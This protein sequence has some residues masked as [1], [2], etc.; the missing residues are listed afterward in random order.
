MLRVAGTYCTCGY[1]LGNCRFTYAHWYE[2]FNT[3][4]RI[5]LLGV[6]LCGCIDGVLRFYSRAK[7]EVIQSC[8][9]ALTTK[10]RDLVMNI[11]QQKPSLWCLLG[12][13]LSMV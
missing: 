10:A 12:A 5:R 9:S 2:C 3:G 8:A 1:F 7:K 13:V 11:Y 6:C 4:Q